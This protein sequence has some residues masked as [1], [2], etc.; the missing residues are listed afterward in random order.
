[1]S[2]ITAAVDWVAQDPDATTRAELTALI[3]AAQGGDEAALGELTE[4]FSSRLAFGTA[5]LRGPVQAGPTGMNRVLVSQAA[6]GLARYLAERA[7]PG[8]TPSVVIG[9]DGRTNSDVFARDTA[10][11]VAGAGLRA[12]LLP[13]LLPTP[14]L[15]FAVRELDASAGVMVTASHNPP[16]DNGYKVYLGGADEGSQIVPPADSAI[17]A[18]I[19]AVAEQERVT[20]LPRSDDY[21][22]ATEDVVDAYVAATASLASPRDTRASLRVV[23]TAMHGVG[24]ETFAAVAERAGFS[25]IEPVVEQRDPDAA[26]PTVAFPNPEEA[27][28]LDLAVRDA[29]A[30]HAD[31]IIANDPDAD[32]MSVAIPD[33]AAEGGYRQ[34]SGNEVGWLLGWQAAQTAHGLGT[35]GALAASIVSSPA[36]GEVA[37]AYG[38]EFVETLTGFKWVSRVPGLLFGYE[39]ALGYLVNPGTLRDKDGISAAVAFLDLAERTAADGGSIAG[40]LD[41]FA[42]RF[43]HFASS[44]LSVRVEDLGII[45]AVMAR[46][47]AETPTVLGGLAV[48][49]VDDLLHPDEGPST[50]A[51]RFVLAG[52][53]RVMAR[54]SGT[55]PKLKF[56]LDVR[57][58]AANRAA[59]LL[60]AIRTDL[61]AIVAEVAPGS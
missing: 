35:G 53:S 4:R 57:V 14:V 28:A 43:G 2:A 13:R 12:I 45:G 40:L 61:S 37:S 50:D 48:D 11:I 19:T 31:L 33:A 56:Y 9:Y 21:A 20:E 25:G 7:E 3:E 55:E 15:A 46:L 44:Q 36:L 27:G 10:E 60:E 16:R 30:A 38:L 51:L 24:W 6:A 42:E 26:F 49:R 32:R 34:L 52:G 29:V 1:M 8:T 59:P 5:G 39:E 18:A 22:I 17:A 47:R 41:E 58:D 54:P 23:Y